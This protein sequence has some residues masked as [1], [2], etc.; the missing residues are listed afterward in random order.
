MEQKVQNV[1][2]QVSGLY[3]RKWTA[4]SPHGR[5]LSKYSSRNLE[6]LII[7]ISYCLVFSGCL[8]FSFSGSTAGNFLIEET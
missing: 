5:V 2:L 8:S 3:E 7:R 1:T 6:I 4:L